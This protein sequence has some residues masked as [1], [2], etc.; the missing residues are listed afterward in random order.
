MPELGNSP[1]P[2]LVLSRMPHLSPLLSS[3]ALRRVPLALAGAALIAAC[4]A[5]SASD[6]VTASDSLDIPAFDSVTVR[7]V[8]ASA[9]PPHTA[10]VVP[11]APKLSP[12]ADSIGGSLVFM[13][14]THRA[15]T[16]AG[17][18]QRLLVDLGRVDTKVK[19]PEELRA[20][21]EAVQALAPVRVGDRLRLRGP[22]G[23]DDAT[24]SGF[25][26]WNGRIVATLAVPPAVDS[27]ARR[28]EA[29]VA[30]VAPADSASGV[31][32][33]TCGRDSLSA[34][35]AA[36]IPI[37]RDSLSRLLQADTASLSERLEKSLRTHA[38]Q[39]I[40][41]FGHGARVALFVTQSA[42]GYQ[43][44]RE[45]AVLL[46]SAGTVMPL[47]VSDPRF[48]AHEALRALDADGDGVDDIAA[49]GRGVR[50]GGTVVLRLD[51]PKRRLEYWTSGF[52]W[53]EF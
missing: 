25:D 52:A 38:S 3:R 47:R 45:L 36:R 37:V 51:A 16:A 18:G 9:A 40:G 17:R 22:W 50:I 20:Y 29:L 43:Y 44:A 15:L 53:E 27:L 19:S 42:G 11:R 24:I 10:R 23:V 1:V 2:S 13:V 28:K 49:R 12:L 31:V 46:D 4:A 21:Q 30:V 35:F 39:A 33:D 14:K 32:A 41:C 48:R 8:V 5:S 26:L 7:Q 6:R 34:E